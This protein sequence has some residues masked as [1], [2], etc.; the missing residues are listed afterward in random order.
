MK[1]HRSE[2]RKKASSIFTARRRLII[3]TVLTYGVLGAG[4]IFMLFPLIWAFVSSFKVAGKVLI[5]P[6][7]WIPDPFTFDNYRS[8]FLYYPFL[9]YIRNSVLV[10]V[11]RVAGVTLT[12]AL[13]AYAF[14]RISFPGRNQLFFLYLST[15]MVPFFVLVIPLYQMIDVWGWGD[16]LYGLAIPGL[17]HAYTTFLLRQF[18]L[19]IPKEL[20]DAATIDGAGKL[21]IFLK[22]MLPLCKPALVTIALFM[23]VWSWNDFFWPLV[24]TE[25]QRSITIPVAISTFR[26]LLDTAYNLQ[27]AAT[28]VAILPV[29]ILFLL[30][31]R[32]F[33]RGIVFTGIKG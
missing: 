2:E 14:A 27:M 16:S 26:R 13:S 30:V 18:F 3:G 8:I 5:I 29:I 7:Q 1:N 24:V 21:R 9:N 22:V 11:A 17:A 32:F 28:V 33:I 25:T 12:S 31:Q 19:T 10:T 20:E 4:A 15:M 6:P 23:S